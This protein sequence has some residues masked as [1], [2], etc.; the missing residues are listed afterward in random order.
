MSVKQIE[1]PDIGTVK[2]YKRR[3]MRGIRLS[4]TNEQVVRVTMPTWLPFSA[5]IE[6]VKSREKWIQQH[7]TPVKQLTQDLDIGK[8]HYLNFIKSPALAKPQGRIVGTQVRIAY[9]T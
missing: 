1:L 3:G 7:R 5:G 8:K 2:L 6:F 9:P 4:L